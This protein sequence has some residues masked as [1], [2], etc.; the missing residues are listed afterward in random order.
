MHLHIVSFTV[1]W[2]ADYGG[3]IDVFYRIKALSE[4]GVRIHLHCYEY[5]RRPAR[6]LDELCEEVL[7]YPRETGMRHQ[8][9]IAP[10]IVASRR[11][12][13][14]VAR[15]QQD[16]YPILIEGLHDCDVL[17]RLYDGTRRIVVRAHN[18]EHDY[19]RSLSRAERCLWKKAFFCVEARKLARYEAVLTKASSVLAVTEKDAE[20]FRK[21]GCHKVHVLP[22][23]H[24]HKQVSSKLGF[25]DYVLYQG[26]LSV[27]ENIGAVRFL[28]QHLIS[29]SQYAFVIA[30]RNPVPEVRDMLTPH[31]NATLIADP[32]DERMCGLIANAHVNVLVTEQATGAKLKLVNALYEGRHCLVNPAMVE[33]TPLGQACMVAESPVAMLESLNRLMATEFSESDLSERKRVLHECELAVD[34]NNILFK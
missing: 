13:K 33:G 18:V 26:N 34:V 27:P 25:G 9:D 22:P 14:L 28:E 15:L 3:V 32:S 17:E 21:I 4:C 20:H 7:Y 16:E 29:K 19:Y 30:G 31:G 5:G 24:G 1:P 11:S 12:A 23:S 2:P 10:Y 8:L 6:E